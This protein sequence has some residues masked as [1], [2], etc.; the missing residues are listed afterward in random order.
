VSSHSTFTFLSR[1]FDSLG[2]K[3]SNKE[4]IKLFDKLD[5]EGLGLLS[6]EDL[7]VQVFP[8]S[9][10]R[11]AGEKG[12]TD[13]RAD[14]DLRVAFRKRPDLL[15]EVVQQLKTIEAQSEYVQH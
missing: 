11:R 12:V 2:V 8:D 14:S 4:I 13:A 10:L 3:V 15:E 6:H 7:I 1:T 5:A 9:V